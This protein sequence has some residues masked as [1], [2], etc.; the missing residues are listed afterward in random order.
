MNEIWKPFWDGKYE[1]SNLGR[2][3]RSAPGRRT[4]A[5]RLLSPI[6]LSVGYLAI[7]PVQNGKNRQAYV[8]DLVAHAFVGPKPDGYC[9]NHIDGNKK[10]NAASN[11]EY[12][13]HRRNMEH[14]S[15][16]GLMASGSRH[17][18]W[19]KTPEVV[20]RVIELRSSGMSYS[21][22]ATAVGVSISTAWEIATQHQIG[23]SL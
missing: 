12:V 9:V 23:A 18:A 7:R 13:T 3:R 4:A 8:H 1:V 11:L 20:S 19:K 14:A 17:P 15:E 6:S 2:A 22:V 5:G 10:N 21:K 16:T